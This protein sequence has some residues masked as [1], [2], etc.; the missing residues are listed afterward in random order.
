MAV[1]VA[2]APSPVAPVGTPV[3]SALCSVELFAGAGGL[4]LGLARAGFDHA[5]VVDKDKASCDTLRANAKEANGHSRGWPIRRRDVRWLRYSELEFV[6]LLSAGA[7]CQPFSHAGLLRGE[8]DDRNMFAEV[9]RAIRH[10]RPR[11]FILE[12]VR[13][14]V[15]ERSRPYFDYLLAQLRMPIISRRGRTRGQHLAV[16]QA[17]ATDRHEYRVEWKLLN[18][19]DY[20]LPQ[21]RVR[22]V[23]IGMRADQAEW[24]WPA[25][26]HS[27]ESLVN[28]LWRDPYWDGHRVPKRVR[29]AVRRELPPPS[30]A[31]QGPRWRTLRDL[32]RRLGPPHTGPEP[33]PSGHNFVPGAR[34]Y[35]RHTGS[36]LDWPGKT[37]K[38]GVHG[39][40]GG[41]H[42]MIADN[43]SIR[44]LTVRECAALQGFP[45][46]YSLPTVRT[47]AMRQLGNAVPVDLAEALGRQMVEVL[48]G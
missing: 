27:R 35:S 22:L 18:A 34:L 20:G 38:A 23:V 3:E 6:D 30:E 48:N 45:D 41:E 25:A 46:D 2:W 19:A 13:G 15:F 40:P 21:N 24:T 4:A 1:S 12:N 28:A 39:C 36:R 16:L 17:I 33:D 14:L 29:L 47:Q 5:L 43:G 32:T 37:V 42:I 7:P 44:Y 31:P 9:V 8:D 26:T 10:L 11:S